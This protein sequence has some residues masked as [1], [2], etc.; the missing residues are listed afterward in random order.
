MSV[1]EVWGDTYQITVAFRGM[2]NFGA[3]VVEGDIITTSRFDNALELKKVVKVWGTLM[4]VAEEKCD[5][6]DMAWIR[7]S[8]AL[9]WKGS[10]LVW[11]R[12]DLKNGIILLLELGRNGSKALQYEVEVNE[13]GD[14]QVG[15]GVM[16]DPAYIIVESPWCNFLHE[17]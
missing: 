6:G 17:I 12:G 7:L 9:W 16:A 5:G 2:K 1:V 8:Y 13:Y 15:E 10:K 14:M 11:E 3:I 4:K